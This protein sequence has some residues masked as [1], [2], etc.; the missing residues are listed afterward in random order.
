MTLCASCDFATGDSLVVQAATKG[1]TSP[2]APE[3]TADGVT[4]KGVAGTAPCDYE[5]T[6]AAD[7]AKHKPKRVSLSF[8]GN[9]GTACVGGRTGAALVE[10]YRASLERITRYFAGR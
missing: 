10:N 9:N 8:S 7:Y 6:M 4:I 1:Q 2:L 3:D 5:R